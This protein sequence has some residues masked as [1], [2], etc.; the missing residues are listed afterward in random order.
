VEQSTATDSPVENMDIKFPKGKVSNVHGGMVVGIKD[1][2]FVV[3]KNVKKQGNDFLLEIGIVSCSDLTEIRIEKKSNLGC[4]LVSLIGIVFF[5][6]LTFALATSGITMGIFVLGLIA[7]LFGLYSS[8]FV[9][10]WK[11][12]FIS[13]GFNLLYN[14]DMDGRE[15]VWN[16]AKQLTQ[17][18][19]EKKVNIKSL[20][21]W[22][23]K[24]SF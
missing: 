10:K 24:S 13:N 5:A 22:S 2:H 11:I 9:K 20:K 12:L 6:Y 14:T 16:L 21:E 7:G 8:L 19:S 3:I 18:G 23:R 15:H 4:G 1:D 17:W